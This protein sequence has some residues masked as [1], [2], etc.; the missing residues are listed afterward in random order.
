MS[1]F[2]AAWEGEADAQ[3]RHR[4]RH[5]HMAKKKGKGDGKKDGKKD[6]KAKAVE[7]KPQPQPLKEARG[8]TT[9]HNEFIT[10]LDGE[11]APGLRGALEHARGGLAD[12]AF[13]TDIMTEGMH[14]FRVDVV[15]SG[16]VT[17]AAYG[18]VVGVADAT[19]GI[20]LTDSYGGPAWGLHLSSARF[21]STLDSYERGYLGEP[22]LSAERDGTRGVAAGSSIEVT[23]DM[24]Q[25][26]VSYAVN[27]GLP[28]R[29]PVRLP[30][31][32]RPWVLLGWEGDQIT[33]HPAT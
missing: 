20:R 8:T 24:E 7:P 17:G 15:K 11:V 30:P 23:V 2:K 26:T 10:D 6:A 16:S 14:T 22:A 28:S 25:R 27:G 9:Q 21:T 18:I 5:T 33:V 12:A 32:V 4:G 31:A 1:R 3:R 29:A 19:E 13:G